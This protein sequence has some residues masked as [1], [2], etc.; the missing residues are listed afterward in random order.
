[1]SLVRGELQNSGKEKD[2]DVTKEIA[3]F[4][5]HTRLSDI[6]SEAVDKA[7]HCFIDCMGCALAGV[8]DDAS[9]IV[10]EYIEM[11]GGKAQASIIG[12]NV[13]TDL[14]H[15]AL[16]NGVIA[17]AQDFDD[18]HNETVIHATA[19]CLPAILS[20]AEYKNLSGADVLH[21]LVLSID[22]II[23][24]GLG[25]TPYHYE[26]GWHT[27]ATAGRFGAVAGASKLLN[28][29]PD[30]I[31]NALGIC[32]TQTSGLRQVFGTMCKPFHA[33][34]ASMDGVMSAL[35]AE[36]GFTSS[37]QIIEG[38]LGFFEVL[39]ENPNERI[40]LDGLGSKFYV[41]D[42]SFKPYPTCA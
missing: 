32:G 42:L 18:Y 21:A 4:I 33:G 6:P 8:N 36:K 31:I 1:M 35:L 10:A 28:L 27:T 23:R 15:A 20:I 25:L 9:Q 30:R 22:I 17:H 19:A 38:E 41:T 16:A 12:K 11:M 29:D 13:K 14:A 34:K 24:L 40:V 37:K 39:T 2:M 5:Y 3:E 26:R 7:K